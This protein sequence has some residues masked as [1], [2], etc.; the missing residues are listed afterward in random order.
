MRIWWSTDETNDSQYTLETSLILS[1]PSSSP[2]I[3]PLP[4][5]CTSSCIFD[6]C[7]LNLDNKVL[8]QCC[9][10][11]KIQKPY[12]NK[13]IQPHYFQLRKEWRRNSKNLC[14]LPIADRLAPPSPFSCSHCC[15]GGMKSGGQICLAAVVFVAKATISLILYMLPLCLPLKP[16]SLLCL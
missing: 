1:L 10:I 8:K 6:F 4:T 5:W 14:V 3:T 15:G 13:K 9:L 12:F 7:K 16:P 11:H 2:S